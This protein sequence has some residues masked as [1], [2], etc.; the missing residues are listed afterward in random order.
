MVDNVILIFFILT[1]FLST[2]SLITEKGVVKPHNH[3]FIYFYVISFCFMYF[4]AHAYWIHI[5]DCYI[6]GELISLYLWI[7]FF[8]FGNI[9]CWKSIW[10]YITT[11]TFWWMLTWYVFPHSFMFHLSILIM[12]FIH[13][14]GQT[15]GWVLNFEIFS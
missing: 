13:F 3:V 6:F 10:A 14:Q 7:I 5:Y 2:C 12:F 1:N 15:Y 4:E 9:L 8:V 11:L